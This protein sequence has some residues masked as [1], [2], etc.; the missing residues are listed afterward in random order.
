MNTLSDPHNR[1]CVVQPFPKGKNPMEAIKKS[2]L[3]HEGVND[4]FTLPATPAPARD[5][6]LFK[7]YRKG[8]ELLIAIAVF[9]SAA[10][11]TRHAALPKPNR[12]NIEIHFAPWNDELGWAQACISPEGPVKTFN[13][14]PYPE[15]ASTAFKFPGIKRHTWET[16][17]SSFTHRL[18]WLF[19]WF[20][21]KDMFRAGDAAGFNV[22]RFFQ[23]LEE[24]SSWNHCGAVGFQDARTYGKIFLKEPAKAQIPNANVGPAKQPTPTKDFKLSVTYDIPDNVGCSSGYTP[25]RLDRELRLWKSYGVDRVY[26]IEYGPLS[27]WPSLWKPKFFN[28]TGAQ[29]EAM[30]RN[31]ELTQ[32]TC[33]DTLKW[34]VKS[35]KRHGM[36]IFAVYKPFD[37]GFNFSFC[38][39]DGYSCVMDADSRMVVAHPDIAAN[40]KYTMQANPAWLRKPV[41]PI[42]GLTL[43]S[44]KPIEAFDTKKLNLW[45]ST[46][47]KHFTQYKGALKVKL[48]TTSRPNMKWT[49]AGVVQE[50]G[51][52]ENWSIELSG[53][54][55]K[56][57]FLAL[58][59]DGERICVS[60]RMFA[61]VQALGPDDAL[62]PVELS[63]SGSRDKGFHFNKYWPGWANHNEPILDHYTWSGAPMCLRFGDAPAIST[64]LEPTY[65]Q[66]RKVWLKHVKRILAAGVDGIDIRTIGHHSGTESYLKFA[67]AQPVREEFKRQTGREVEAKEED[68]QQIRTIRGDAYTQFLKEASQVIRAGGKKLATHVE[69]GTEVPSNLTIRLQM[70]MT[71]QWERWIKE[72]IV[73]EISLRGWGIASRQ[74]HNNIFPLTRKHN[75]GVHVIS[76]CLPGGID[77]RAMELCPRLVKEAQ[78]AGFAGYSFYETDSFMRMNTQGYPMPVGLIDEAIGA[79]RRALDEG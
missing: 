70:Q 20:S 61:F 42:K 56:T 43:W 44:Q 62:S 1:Y 64:L 35:A 6:T 40:Q 59:I 28:L 23:P 12:N 14:V 69:W 21:V 60:H 58:E 32:R 53:L 45:T 34:A 48:G 37:L 36:E 27:Q 25:E 72:G 39:D 75:V 57:P 22:V 17:E 24:W 79:A 73:D 63:S 52:Q 31:V 5:Q 26:W 68:Y 3:L 10:P 9:E 50:K 74:V 65:E 29:K 51:S 13:H 77:I 18:Y 71:L 11:S 19:A 15:L 33:D 67:F 30:E 66:A 78:A 16:D 46:D 4:R 8:D 54:N 55:V 47:N 2:I 38:E 7:A 41:L 76:T 49:P